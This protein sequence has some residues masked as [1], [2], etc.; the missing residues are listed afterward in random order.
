MTTL[1]PDQRLRDPHLRDPHLRDQHLAAAALDVQRALRGAARRLALRGGLARAG[2]ML[3]A[4]VVLLEVGLAATLRLGLTGA[5]VP[6]AAALVLAPTLLLLAPR[7]GPEVAAGVLDARLGTGAALVTAAEAL[8]G[9]HG[10]LGAEAVLEGRRALDG[11]SPRAAL[12]LQAPAGLLLGAAAAALLPAVLFGARAELAGASGA[13]GGA[14]PTLTLDLR[15][16]GGGGGGGGGGDT[17][18]GDALPDLAAVS[19]AD[20]GVAAGGDDPLSALPPEVAAVVRERLEAALQPAASAAGA[21]A[22]G[23]GDAGDAGGEADDPLVR[24]LRA[25]DG[26]A[27][28]SAL[29]DL[30]RDAAQGDPRAARRLEALARE[31]GRAGAGAGG[32]AD[33]G[34]L[35]DA[36][37]RAGGSPTD[38]QA[39]PWRGGGARARLPL[40]LEL[41]SRRY[42]ESSPGVTRPARR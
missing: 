17:L 13:A 28:L 22:E 3:L 37:G 8:D 4:G 26:A 25:G 41:A 14:T 11:R 16:P 2:W 6:G 5:W 27:A 34:A 15:P 32:A 20:P 7:P 40:E 18:P 30:T 23:A 31:A 21:A 36:P 35:A 24:A 19:A 39:G 9:R 10:R 33:P 29:D 42:F 1:A 38:S 12:P